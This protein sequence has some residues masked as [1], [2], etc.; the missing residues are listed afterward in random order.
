MEALLYNVWRRRIRE[1][2]PSYSVKM[3]FCLLNRDWFNLQTP[4]FYESNLSDSTQKLDLSF[5]AFSEIF[6]LP[7]NYCHLY[8]EQGPESPNGL[9]Q[10]LCSHGS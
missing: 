3:Q 4:A 9:P 7:G 1:R 6:N 8:P 5:G 10:T 2:R